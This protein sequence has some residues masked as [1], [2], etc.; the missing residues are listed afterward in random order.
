MDRKDFLKKMLQAG[1]GIFC[2][3]AVTGQKILGQMKQNL[4][5]EPADKTSRWIG[6]LEK[7]MIEGARTP[8]WRKVEFAELWVKRLMENMDE[9]LDLDT[10][11]ILMQACGRSC[12][13][14]AFGVKDEK[15]PTPE[16]LDN[17]LAQFQ[18]RG[19]KEIRREG[20]TVYFQYGLAET[21]PYGLRLQDGFCMCPLM[22]S[23]SQKISS[24]YCQCSAGYIK[25]MFGRFIDGPLEVEVLETLRTGGKNCKFKI[26]ILNP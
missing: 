13:L 1:T 23:A 24:T 5:Q 14:H 9:I 15:K 22:E 6:E 10:K 21:N 12:Y 4:S 18:R 8:A 17:I 25:E 16:A 2:C 11:K 7:R 20:N 3:G 19:D 26:E